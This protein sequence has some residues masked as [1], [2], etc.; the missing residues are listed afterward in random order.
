[1]PRSSQRLF[2]G[3]LSLNGVPTGA[4]D[5]AVPANELVTR[6]GMPA[7]TQWGSCWANERVAGAVDFERAVEKC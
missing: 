1:M 4:E 6:M 7:G 3:S 5:D 2:P